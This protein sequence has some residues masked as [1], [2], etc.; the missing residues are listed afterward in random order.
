MS[1]KALIYKLILL[2]KLSVLI[3][4]YNFPYTFKP[5]IKVKQLYFPLFIIS[6]VVLLQYITPDPELSNDHGSPYEF[7]SEFNDYLNFYFDSPNE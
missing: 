3:N 6:N 5:L 1:S 4:V 2:R 7:S